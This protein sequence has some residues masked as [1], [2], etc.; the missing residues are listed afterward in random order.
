MGASMMRLAKLT[1]GMLLASAAASSWADRAML[2]R[3][4]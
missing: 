1:A 3:A 2:S 4:S